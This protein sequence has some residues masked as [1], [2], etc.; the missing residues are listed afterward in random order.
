M[1]RVG[2]LNGLPIACALEPGAG[3][4]QVE[5]WN[6]FD[7]EYA[8]AVER[9]DTEFVVHYAK[10][11][12]SMRRLGDLVETEQTCCSFVDWSIDDGGADL[13]LV[14]TGSSERLAALTIGL[15]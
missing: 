14:V 10:V 13:R 9:T 1:T 2:P 15:G 8:L 3:R 11:D 7:D 5:R 4:E 12:D 6:A